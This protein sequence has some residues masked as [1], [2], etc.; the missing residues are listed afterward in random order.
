MGAFTS[1]RLVPR[2]A[3]QR[4]P[5]WLA[6]VDPSHHRQEL[7]LT[8]PGLAVTPGVGLQVSPFLSPE[9][10]GQALVS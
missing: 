7:S 2:V 1:P 10:P 9:L 8:L 6:R 4:C 3:A 5:R